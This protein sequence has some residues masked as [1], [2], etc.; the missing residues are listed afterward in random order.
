MRF[1]RL[2]R[3]SAVGVDFYQ[4]TMTVSEMEN[5]EENS[6]KGKSKMVWAPALALALLWSSCTLEPGFDETSHIQTAFKVSS[7]AAMDGKITV[8]QAYLK[9]DRIE[10]NGGLNGKNNTSLTHPIPAEEPPYNLTHADSGEVDFT[11]SSRAYDQ[12]HVHLFP[13]TDAYELVYLGGTVENPPPADEPEEEPGGDDGNDE[14][15]QQGGDDNAGGEDDNDNEDGDS[16]DGAGGNSAGGDD[17]EEP[18]GDDSDDDS[19]DDS[20][21]GS[22]DKDDED[23]DSKDDKKDKGD[24]DK[25]KDNKDKNKDKD[26]DNK[27]RDDKKHDDDD[28]DR[29][30]DDGDHDE[31]DDNDG[32]GN[33]RK[34]GNGNN[35]QVDLDHFFRNA[36]PGLVVFGTYEHNGKVITLIIV[37]TDHEKLTIR[38]RQDDNFSI[39][40]AEN[41]TAQL[42]FD[43]AYWFQSLTPQDIEGATIQVYQQQNVLFIHPDHNTALYQALV[44]RLEGSADLQISK[45]GMEN[46]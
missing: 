37:V 26:K 4:P 3:L 8:T 19:N 11:V 25:D 16:N 36:K 10:V 6:G 45:A 43:P 2:Y 7:P 17:G 18:G 40:L 42:S 14:D 39:M 23:D 31:D 1:K 34:S 22:G 33:D 20:D 27:D 32:D 21:D 46:F 24:K 44:S 28:D 9:L 41:N 5:K 35:S 15:K 29:D 13:F 12:L 38:G 30:D